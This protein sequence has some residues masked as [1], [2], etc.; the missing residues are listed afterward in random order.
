VWLASVAALVAAALAGEW[1]YESGRLRFNYPSHTRFPVRGIDVSHHQGLVDW[2]TVARSGIH[3]AFIKATEGADHSDLRFEENW[4]AAGRAGLARGAYHYFTFCTP[5]ARQAEHFIAT[6]APFTPELPPGVNVE[7]SGN[8]R[9]WKSIAAIRRELAIFLS[10]VEEAQGV[11][12]VLYLTR[13]SGREI[14]HGHFPRHRLWV[15][16]ILFEPDA[17]RWGAWRFWQYA[18]NARLP[19][20]HGPVDLNVFCCGLQQLRSAT[21]LHSTP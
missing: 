8:C 15:R 6:L 7:F 16:D 12:P 20:I 1:L 19:G 3:F 14:A 11:R 10:R 13:K 4:Q 17:T 2:E 18:D 9:A 21:A 5:G